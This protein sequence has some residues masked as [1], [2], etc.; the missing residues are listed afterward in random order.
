MPPPQSVN[1][2]R[3]AIVEGAAWVM[4][5]VGAGEAEAKLMLG[6]RVEGCN[7]AA[8]T[9]RIPL[10]HPLALLHYTAAQG[11][12]V[13]AHIDDLLSSTNYFHIFAFSTYCL[14]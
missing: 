1:E 13:F 8:Y 7:A 3:L 11:V 5:R 9:N 2:R 6:A 4:I 12:S 10:T 14:N